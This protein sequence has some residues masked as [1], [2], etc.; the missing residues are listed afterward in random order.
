MGVPSRNR[1][2][3]SSEKGVTRRKAKTAASPRLPGRV[4][5]GLSIR[6][7]K[8][9][10]IIWLRGSEWMAVAPNFRTPLTNV[11]GRSRWRRINVAVISV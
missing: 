9:I 7:F 4:K 6:C 8:S 10:E 5:D 3:L 2:L 1:S 11:T